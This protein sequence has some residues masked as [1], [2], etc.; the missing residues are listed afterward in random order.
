MGLTLFLQ[1]FLYIRLRRQWRLRV[2]VA[3]GNR[4]GGGLRPL[5]AR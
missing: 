5:K 3:L 1:Q 2:S 4:G